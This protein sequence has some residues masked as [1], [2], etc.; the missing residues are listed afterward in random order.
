LAGSKNFDLEEFM[1]IQKPWGNA[2]IGQAP[3]GSIYARLENSCLFAE[4]ALHDCKSTEGYESPLRHFRAKNTGEDHAQP[5]EGDVHSRIDAAADRG[6]LV[7]ASLARETEDSITLHLEWAP[8]K[9][10]I[11]VQE[12]TIF[13]D[14]PYLKV[15]YLAWFVN[16]VDIASPGGC[17][18]GQYHIYG[19]E[20]WKR[21]YTYY[22]DIYYCRHPGDVGYQNITEIDD[23]TPLTYRDHFIMGVFNPANGRGF[24]RVAPVEATDIIKL[25][26]SDKSH[27]GFEIF[28]YYA[29]EHKPF[30]N[31]IYAFDDGAEGVVQVGK[32][33][34]DGIQ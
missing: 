3:D 25:L 29:R 4:Y 19:A 30:Y 1:L 22:E 11:S 12:V 17:K 21:P 34:V 15:D 2:E 32:M 13:K 24:G 33:I 27:R 18:N 23:P 16:I 10:P 5:H 31:Y 9:L 28:A 20:Y 26:L 7:K 14:Q 6:A 8:V